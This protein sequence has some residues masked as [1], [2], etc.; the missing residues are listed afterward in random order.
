VDQGLGV[1][2]WGL[3]KNT[4]P[5]AASSSPL[6]L[7][8]GS[9]VR[10]AATPRLHPIPNPQSPI[11]SAL[12][13]FAVEDTGIGIPRAEL[14]RVFQPFAQADPSTTR[15]F[16]GTGLGLTISSH[17]VEAM[18]GRIRV[19]SQP[20]QGSTFYFTARF[21]LA[22]EVPAER[23]APRVLP[24][25]ASP[26][27]ILLVE[28]N[29]A[30][31]KLASFVLQERGHSVDIAADGREGL[32][33]AEQ[34]RYDVILMDVQMPG[35]DGLEATQAIRARERGGSRVPI[36]AMTAH[37]VKGDR[38]RCLA[39]GMDGYLSKPIV[40]QEM[41][42][43]LESLGSGETLATALSPAADFASPCKARVFDDEAAL[44]RCLNRPD[45][46]AEIIQ[47]YFNDVE[48]ILPQVRVALEKGD[49]VG[50]GHLGHRLKGTVVN[51][52]AE[53]ARQAALGVEQ[54]MLRPGDQADAAE[55][56]E[57]LERECEI[58]KTALADYLSE[59]IGDER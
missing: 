23:H 48:A 9:G 58:L 15:R 22:D 13:E 51:L 52:C 2:D 7:G 12:L 36:I 31:Q 24:K 41:I 56:V 33:Q 21:P 50:M 8:E 49:L 17:L 59:R 25:A 53:A 27:R 42:A 55:A 10:A 45:V 11:P 43:L 29:Q 3:E 44:K 28:D 1:R 40:A 57:A 20:G 32:R 14:K 19:E 46:L 5:A 34:N 47:C 39:A 30:N 38:E 54:F 35:M 18:G 4:Q 6:P 26:L 37:A 16:G